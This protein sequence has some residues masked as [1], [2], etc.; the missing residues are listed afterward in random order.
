MEVAGD[1][2]DLGDIP[3]AMDPEPTRGDNQDVPRATIAT[4]WTQKFSVLKGT[5]VREDLK[6]GRRVP[7]E[8][9]LDVGPK[10]A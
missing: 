7:L 4:T 1:S 6:Q 9:T 3:L 8:L 2:V 10:F 5:S